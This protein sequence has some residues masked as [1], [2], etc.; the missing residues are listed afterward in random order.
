MA[1][2]EFYYNA[3]AYQEIRKDV[4]AR[5]GYVHSG[6]ADLLLV[7][8]V[9]DPETGRPRIDFDEMVALDIDLLV[10][11]KVF[12]TTSRLLERICQSADKAV[13]DGQTLSVDKFSDQQVLRT[14]LRGCMSKVVETLKLDSILGARHFI[15]GAHHLK[16]E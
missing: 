5:S 13:A 4:S 7:N 12:A 3:K 8:V 9:N 14:F 2:I 11:E 10:R 15:V 1:A 16:T 6:E